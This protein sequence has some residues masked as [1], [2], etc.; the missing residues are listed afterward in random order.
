MASDKA[1]GAD[2]VSVVDADSQLV[3]GLLETGLRVSELASLRRDR[4]MKPVG[5]M[6][7]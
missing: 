6:V 4:R 1:D 3:W 5:A 2:V 7:W